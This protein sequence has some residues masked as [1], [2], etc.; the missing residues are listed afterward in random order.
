MS[1]DLHPI[2]SIDLSAVAENYRR[3]RTAAGG[4]C[5][6]VVKAD[7]YG[8]GA[9]QV[10]ARLIR[11]DCQTF[12][13]ATVGEAEILR[14]SHPSIRLVVFEGITP[15]AIDRYR[16]HNLIPT[17][18][19]LE[20]I[21]L[22]PSSAE[23][24]WHVDTGMNRL[25]LDRADL[26]E[27]RDNTAM[28]SGRHSTLMTHFVDAD[29]EEPSRSRQQYNDFF[30][31]VE[32]IPHLDTS[33]G[34]TAGLLYFDDL[35]S[36]LGRPGIGLYGGNPRRSQAHFGV[37]VVQL[38][39]PIL[40]V[41]DISPGDSV[42]YNATFT[43]EGPRTI[44]TAAL[45]YAD[46]LFRSSSLRGRVFIREQACPMVGRV[47]MDSV[48]IDVTN[49]IGGCRVG[50]RAEFIGQRSLDDAA[51]EAGTT[52]YEVLTALGERIQRAYT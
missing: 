10:V 13:V 40:Q 14:R 16:H 27:L 3:L 41:R 2:L 28:F 34:N 11:E 49:L 35:R 33:L 24:F 22:W 51:D 18:N 26:A 50:D 45:G 5:G 46:G 23:A 36:S 38:S 44:A 8:L 29:E 30:A 39:A 6:A 20:Q 15:S 32:D 4:R 1:S 9:E 42:G 37:P 17:L 48:G 52:V 12:F 47:S 21:R 31:L 19:S 43:A 25:G 7:A